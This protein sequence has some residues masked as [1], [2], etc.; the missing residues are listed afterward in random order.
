MGREARWFREDC[1]GSTI[2]KVCPKA[3]E[4]STVG[5]KGGFRA[6]DTSVSGFWSFSSLCGICHYGKFSFDFRNV[7][8]SF[9]MA[10]PGTSVSSALGGWRADF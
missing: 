5:N 1:S 3:E 8:I 7:L 2:E 9:G 6:A 10:F 4:G